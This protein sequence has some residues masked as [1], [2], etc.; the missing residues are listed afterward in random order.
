MPKGPLEELLRK[1]VLVRANGIT[2]KGILL[3][4]TDQDVVIRR[5]TS[6]I[7]IPMDR[8]ISIRPVTPKKEQGPVRTVD[9]SWYRDE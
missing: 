3:E 2:Y 7:S 8:V 6:Q 5:T 9:P 1:P 4:V